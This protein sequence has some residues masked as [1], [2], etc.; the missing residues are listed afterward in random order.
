[1]RTNIIKYKRKLAFLFR[2][3]ISSLVFR[4]IYRN[5]FDISQTILVFG[6]TRC[7][8]TWLAEIIC[9][10]NGGTQIFEPLH[11]R[12]IERAAAVGIQK[13]MYLAPDD[14]WNEGKN[15][16]T[17][18]FSGR[19]I[20]P[21]L[22]SQI[23][24]RQ[25]LNTR[26]LVVKLVRGNLLLEWIVRNFKTRLPALVIRHPC[27]VIAS[28][29]SKGWTPSLR[30]LLSN[31]YL[32]NLQQIKSRCESLNQPEELLAL[33]WCLK[34]HAPLAIPK[35]YP[36]I[37]VCYE[38][39]VRNGHKEIEKLFYLWG[40]ELTDEVIQKIKKPSNTVTEKSQVLSGKDPLAG[41]K[42]NLNSE[43]I[44]NILKVVNIFGMDF[45]SHDSEPDYNRLCS[46]G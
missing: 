16:L 32:D 7:G 36:F 15:Y 28:Q 17:E 30:V 19:A 44:S 10:A 27:A 6:S 21:W 9:A 37:I 12:Y 11:T 45:Y 5:G 8:S 39:L 1:M 46:G 23:T 22:A 13:N 26:Y 3:I 14:I 2:G 41:W 25:A 29:L 38:N 20:N 18:V 24:L 31:P 42:E 35:P 33:A 40:L 4:V 34:Y 43:Q